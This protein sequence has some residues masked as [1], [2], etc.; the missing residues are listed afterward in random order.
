M[1]LP[2]NCHC[3]SLAFSS[4]CVFFD[5]LN[6]ALVGGMSGSELENL[7]ISIWASV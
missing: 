3:T 1:A 6:F 2:L 4:T 5:L 7:H